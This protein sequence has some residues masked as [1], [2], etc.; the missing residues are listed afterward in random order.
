MKDAMRVR[1]RLWGV[2]VILLAAIGWPVGLE[3]LFG[4]DDGVSTANP[5]IVPPADYSLSAAVIGL[6]ENE[7]KEG[8]KHRRIEPNFAQFVSYAGRMLD[9]TAGRAGWS[10]LSGN[11]RLGWYEKLYREPLKAMTETEQFT[12]ELH[13][14]AL[15]DHSGVEQALEM[16]A[17]KLGLKMTQGRSPTQAAS[18]KDALDVVKQAV[19]EARVASLAALAPLTPAE[20]SELQ[21]GLYRVLTEQNVHGHTLEDR[22]SGR[23]QLDLLEKTDRSTAC[24]AALALAPLADAR[25]LEQLRGLRNDGNIAVEGATG[26]VAQRVVTSAGDILIGGKGKNVY[27]LDKISGICAVIDLGGDD[28]YQEGTVSAERPVLVVIDLAG[29]D[30]YIATKP[31]AQGGAV[32]GV[33]M[34]LEL[35]GN[36]VYRARDVAQGSALGGVGI[37]VDFAGDDVY[38]GIRRVQGQAVGGIGILIDREGTDRYHAALWGQGF[39]GPLGFGLLDDLA[40]KDHYSLGGLY[41]NSFKPETPGYDGWGQG[42]GAGLRQV[43][44]GGIGVLLDGGGDDLYEY[45]YMAQ[46]GG[47]WAGV[48]MARDFGGNDRRLGAT[49]NEFDGGPRKEPV[50]QR[51]ACGWGCHYSLG[52]CFDDAGND[53]YGGTIMGLGFGW[54]MSVG[55]LCDFSGN[56][57]YEA[58]GQYTQGCGAE[59]GFG[60]IFDYAGKDVYLGPNQAYASPSISYHSQAVCGGNFSFVVDYGGQDEYGCGAQNNIYNQRGG[61]GGFLVDRPKREEAEQVAASSS[62]RK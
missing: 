46:G 56:D 6:L 5:P 20:H 53:T 57:R 34:L 48:G 23:R 32:L 49:Q 50:F 28:E 39:G 11:C 59:A 54:D 38:A 31:G 41:P 14:A 36:D 62:G 45:D 55:M 35:E 7:I 8:L 10:E 40:G 9:S 58:I 47:Y 24:S 12:R 27:E 13:Q 25:L 30:T 17:Q 19:T 2:V 37:L 4:A 52:Y 1:T 61:A 16:A 29:N 18:P 26:T 42:V 21:Q 22:V 51:Y 3:R 33:S 15:S 43:A 44:N 60:T